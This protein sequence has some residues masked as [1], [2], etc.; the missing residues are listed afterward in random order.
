MKW[1]IPVVT[2]ALAMIATDASAQ[3]VD[4]SG[5][6][7]CVQL[8]RPEFQA[9]PA[10]VTQNGYQMNLVDEGGGAARAWVDYPGHIWVERWGEGAIYSADGDT[11]QFDR[12]RVWQRWVE[13]PPPPVVV[14]RT[15]TRVV[16]RTVK[17]RK[18]RVQ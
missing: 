13:P 3:V 5:K 18:R 7:Q 2:A 6:F 11:I 17:P 12:G 15:V 16:T 1:P 10:F 8:C 14:T 9:A 4:L